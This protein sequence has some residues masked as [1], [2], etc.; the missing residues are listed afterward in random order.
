MGIV[1]DR[2]NTLGDGSRGDETDAAEPE[3][4]RYREITA[5]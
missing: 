3:A 1:L 4:S 2:D 5:I